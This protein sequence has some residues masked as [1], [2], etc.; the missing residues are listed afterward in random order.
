MSLERSQLQ[1]QWG[2]R[3]MAKLR[4]QRL[5]FNSVDDARKAYFARIRSLEKKGYMDATAN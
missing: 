2:L 1:V 5:M 3:S 4:S